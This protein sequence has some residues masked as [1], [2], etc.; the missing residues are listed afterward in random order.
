MK[1]IVKKLYIKSEM[2][3][4]TKLPAHYY[5]VFIKF[6]ERHASS[7]AVKATLTKLDNAWKTESYGIQEESEL[8]RSRYFFMVVIEIVQKTRC[9]SLHNQNTK[10]TG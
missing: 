3:N 7:Q 1:A 2:L 8:K 5:V 10:L 4:K 6:S 9:N